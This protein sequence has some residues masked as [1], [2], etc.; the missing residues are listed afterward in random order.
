M[1]NVSLDYDVV[2]AS[3][4]FSETA[5]RGIV[6]AKELGK[7]LVTSKVLLTGMLKAASE[8]STKGIPMEV[9]NQ[10]EAHTLQELRADKYNHK[11]YSLLGEVGGSKFFI[12]P[13]AK[14]ALVDSWKHSLK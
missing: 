7:G 12:T 3:K 5:K 9:V 1:S 6:L 10:V 8:V 14:Q 11:G 13:A 2:V 4:Y